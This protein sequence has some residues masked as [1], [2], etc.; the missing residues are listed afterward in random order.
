MI[1]T[2][3]K[4]SSIPANYEKVMNEYTIQGYRLIAFAFKKLNTN[5]SY[6]KAMKIAREDAEKD[7]V[8]LGFLISENKLKPVTADTIKTLNECN[9]RTIMATGDNTLTAISVAKQCNILDANKKVY[10]AD[11]I[12]GKLVWQAFDEK[13]S[14]IN[15]V[16]RVNESKLEFMSEDTLFDVPWANDEENSFGVALNGS[17]LEFLHENI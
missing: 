14:A 15:K 2:L 6:L 3:C 7:L 8:F 12:M 13:V 1:R 10:F 4:E 5:T 9:I 16:N 17:T 11:I